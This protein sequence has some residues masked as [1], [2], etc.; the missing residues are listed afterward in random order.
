MK[1]SEVNDNNDKSRLS[2][3]QRICKL[4]GRMIVCGKALVWDYA[5]NKAVP[6]SEMK[7]GSPG[8]AASERAKYETMK[9]AFA[10]N[11]F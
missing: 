11:E 2:G 1:N 3:L 8:W 7:P 10:K 9:Q 4:Y 5:N 6:E